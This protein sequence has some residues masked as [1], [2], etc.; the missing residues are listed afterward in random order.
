M[1]LYGQLLTAAAE[2]PPSPNQVSDQLIVAVGG[3]ITAAIVALGGVLVAIVNSRA[4]KPTPLSPSTPPTTPT[5]HGESDRMLYE[6]YGRT[7]VLNARADDS[8][9]RD[10]LQDRRLDHIERV[11]DLKNSDWRFH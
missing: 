6:L 3:A 8:D 9:E 2:N 11:L 5:T 10:E 7:E 4:N 1:W